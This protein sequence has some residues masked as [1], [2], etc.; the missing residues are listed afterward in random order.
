MRT[1]LRLSILTVCTALTITTKAAAVPY[2]FFTRYDSES[3]LPN[4]TIISCLSDSRGFL[5]VGTKDG[6]YRF[7]GYDFM[8]PDQMLGNEF[9]EGMIGAICEDMDGTIWFSTTK[10]IGYYVPGT[11][12]TRTIEGLKGVMCYHMSADQSGNI[13]FLQTDI[14]TKGI[15]DSVIYKY[16]KT[17]GK[18]SRYPISSGHIKAREIAIDSGQKVWFNAEESPYLYIYNPD[19]DRFDQVS[20]NINGKPNEETVTHIA[21]ASD[22][23]ILASTSKGNVLMVN[24]ITKNAR[25]IYKVE[26]ESSEIR[27]L[28]ER[29]K[30]EYWIGTAFGIYVNIDGQTAHLDH[31]V[32]DPHS[33]SG[34]DIW[35]MSKDLKGNV[36]IG[37]FYNGLNLWQ[38]SSN[39]F[40]VLYDNP[41][42]N[43][44]HGVFIRALCPDGNDNLWI[45]TEDGGLN[46]VNLVSKVVRNFDVTNE[47]GAPINIQGLAIN[48][49]DV[50][51]ASY[52]NGIYVLDRNTGKIRKHYTYPM[53]NATIRI[54]PHGE[55][56]V[57]SRRGLFTL[58][59]K[60]DSFRFLEEFGNGFVHSLLTDSFTGLWVGT[61][62]QG[63]WYGNSKGSDPMRICIDTP[64]YALTNNFIT[65]LYEDSH[66]RLWVTTE[67]A[68]L[69]MAP[70]D[71]IKTGH[72]KFRNIKKGAS[73]ESLSSNVTCAVAEDEQGNIWVST[74]RGIVQIAPDEMEIKEVFI[75]N[76]GILG[77]QYSYG[78]TYTARNGDIFFG[79]NQ[80]LFGFSPTRINTMMKTSPIFITEIRADKEDRSTYLRTPGKSTIDSDVIT[81]K[82]KDIG[83]LN[84]RFSAADISLP[85]SVVYSYTLSKRGKTYKGAS[86]ANHVSFVDITPGRYKFSISRMG[87]E[88]TE[89]MRTINITITP[90]IY[91]SLIAYV[92]YVILLSGIAV[93]LIGLLLKRRNSV[94]S[95]QLEKMEDRKQQEIYK[96]K[97]NFFTNITHE[98]RTPLTLIKMPLDKI[99]SKGDY[100]I[101]AKKDL[102]TMQENTNRLLTLTNQILDMRK[103]DMNETQLRYVK[104]DITKLIKKTYSFFEQNA[105]DQHLNMSIS[106]PD[107]PVEIPCAEDVV[108]T[109][110]SNLLSNAIKYGK[111]TVE[112]L[113]EQTKDKVKIRVNSNGRRISVEDSE[114]IFEMFYQIDNGEDGIQRSNGTGLGLPYARSMAKLHNG[115]LYLDTDYPGWNSF[116]FELPLTQDSHIEVEKKN[117][118]EDG[119]PKEEKDSNFHFILIVEDD[120][121][122]RSY[123]SNELSDEYNTVTAANGEDALKVIQS[124]RIDLV[125]SDIMMPVMDGCQLCNEIK[126]STDYSH[127]P[128]IL[129]TAAVGIETRMET[130]QVGADGYI[131]K[132]FSMELLR[133][134]VSNLFKN[135]EIAY[136]Q[137]VNSPLTHYNSVT[138][139][140]VDQKYMDKLHEVIINNL[141]DHNLNVDTLA[142]M[143]STSKSTLYRKVKGN[144]GLNIN[145]YIRVC[146]LKQAAEMLASQKYRVNEV[147][148]LVGFSS[149]SYFA[150]S[151]QKQFNIS[152]SNFVKQLRGDD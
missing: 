48:G 152:P 90:P 120:P 80:G 111:D 126:S 149:P 112:V 36:W 151:F 18:I 127:I 142:D 129:L 28:M 40:S 20:F 115:E 63:L 5:W 16:S 46:C 82:H 103:M 147:A 141:S 93:V 15:D 107:T 118:T 128:V 33:L 17:D 44:I 117:V 65:S 94:R 59:E 54:L 131:E 87:E 134:N 102:L 140:N 122:M 84:I 64:E 47:H 105:A 116:V 66:R 70:L 19:S 67:G 138:V 3:G 137:F 7:D 130:L 23:G 69:F 31:L 86:T 29:V 124:Q 49:D 85:Q 74:S 79:T 68:G 73:S 95:R 11:G 37:T 10:G 30:G 34:G 143:L 8:V 89:N 4:N 6:L 148:D 99:I 55:V 50:W 41:S 77:E 106:I 2:H 42:E 125:I 38:N 78:A 81:V 100:T 144:T 113:F 14:W 43:S 13:W 145:E 71:S 136:H 76:S 45:G 12:E 108:S 60:T 91:K 146:R 56:I 133:A 98:I 119:T 96:A 52:E 97:L 24:T 62:G 83:S 26:P 121:D 51:I 150:T 139:S 75:K 25:L 104:R 32:T 101:T 58:D 135:R 61:Y 88:K 27:T 132:P 92:L 21:T 109:V 72:F 123:I 53:E 35:C 1:F 114:K 9:N 39:L 110:M 57:G 22:G